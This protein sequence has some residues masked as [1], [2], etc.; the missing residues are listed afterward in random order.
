MGVKGQAK[1]L[2]KKQGQDWFEPVLNIHT[3]V[4]KFCIT[5]HCTINV[6]THL[7]VSALYLSHHQGVIVHRLKQRKSCF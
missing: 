4:F 2:S 6:F 1:E 3:P 5:N 7:Y